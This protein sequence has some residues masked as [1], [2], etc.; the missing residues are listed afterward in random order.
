MGV[1]LKETPHKTFTFEVGLNLQA[2]L[3]PVNK[4]HNKERKLR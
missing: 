1:R 3:K 2:I 4:S